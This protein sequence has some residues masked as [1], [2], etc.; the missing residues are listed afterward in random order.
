[1][2]SSYLF[3]TFKDWSYSRLLHDFH[4]EPPTLYFAMS[5]TTSS[6]HQNV[7]FWAAG[8]KSHYNLLMIFKAIKKL[9]SNMKYSG[10]HKGVLTHMNAQPRFSCWFKSQTPL[11]GREMPWSTWIRHILSVEQSLLII[12]SLMNGHYPKHKFFNNVFTEKASLQT[13]VG[14]LDFHHQWYFISPCNITFLCS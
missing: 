1:M 10:K 14:K 5:M 4:Q 6:W 11:N 3:C 8:A 7:N 9:K 13:L 2:F 12:V